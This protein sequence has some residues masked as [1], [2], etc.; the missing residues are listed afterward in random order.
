MRI[1]AKKQID[2]FIDLKLNSSRK[3]YLKIKKRAV[4]A[5]K[6]FNKYKVAMANCPIIFSLSVLD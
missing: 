1:Y 5:S 6:S 4:T 2:T 3:T